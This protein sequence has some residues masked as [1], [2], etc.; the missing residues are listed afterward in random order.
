MVYL[1]TTSGA[2]TVLVLSTCTRAST[3]VTTCLIRHDGDNHCHH[4]LMIYRLPWGHPVYFVEC[5]FGAVFC[6][7]VK[8]RSH[9]IWVINVQCQCHEKG[10][11]GLRT[12]R[13][14]SSFLWLLKFEDQ[15]GSRWTYKMSSEPEAAEFAASRKN[16]L[17]LLQNKSVITISIF[18][19]I[20][21]F[22]PYL[23]SIFS[24][25]NTIPL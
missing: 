7:T 15:G 8:T 18:A 21:G 4:V 10:N 16:L 19:Y 13:R 5:P 9:I 12:S 25:C 6:P 11:F 2:S 3:L 22:S 23:S 14:L 24:L 1:R 17:L 20:A